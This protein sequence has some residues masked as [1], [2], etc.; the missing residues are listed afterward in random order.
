MK[1]IV[2]RQILS[3]FFMPT[4]LTLITKVYA[5][6]WTNLPVPEQTTTSFFSRGDK[7]YSTNINESRNMSQEN[8]K[9]WRKHL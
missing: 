1:K 5:C 9:R 6:D 3:I 2:L 4:Y 8:R 7:N